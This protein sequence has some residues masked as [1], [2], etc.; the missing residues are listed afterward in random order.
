MKKIFTLLVI[1]LLVIWSLNKFLTRPYDHYSYWTGNWDDALYNQNS[2]EVIVPSYVVWY[3]EVS[4][5]TYGIRIHRTLC[6][7][8]TINWFLEQENTYFILN[9]DTG[10]YIEYENERDLY[11]A[12][13]ELEVLSFDKISEYWLNKINVLKETRPQYFTQCETAT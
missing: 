7:R 8:E 10:S 11:F 1:L 3:K 2:S 6:N 13:T 4:N 9:R 5:V 12:I